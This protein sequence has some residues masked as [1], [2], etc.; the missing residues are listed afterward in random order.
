MNKTILNDQIYNQNDARFTFATEIIVFI[1]LPLKNLKVLWLAP[2]LWVL[3]ISRSALCPWTVEVTCLTCN[4]RTEMRIYTLN[5]FPLYSENEFWAKPPRR[6]F[7]RTSFFP[8]KI[9]RPRNRSIAQLP[10]PRKTITRTISPHKTFLP[11]GI[12]RR[13]RCAGE[14]K[15][16][17]RHLSPEKISIRVIKTV[18]Q[19]FP[20]LCQI[21]TVAH[22]KLQLHASSPPLNKLPVSR[23]LPPFPYF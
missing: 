12:V 4:P 11:R 18:V 13:H 23:G 8:I 14:S 6:M 21:S 3:G 1:S 5:A 9:R 22:Q 20:V 10:I 15:G 7:A 2:L 17:E 19:S 16:S